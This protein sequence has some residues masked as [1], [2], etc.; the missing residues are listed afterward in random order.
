M[1]NDQAIRTGATASVIAHLSLLALLVLLSEVQPLG[2]AT[3]PIAVNI[4]TTE[5]A[6]PEN[7]KAEHKPDLEPAEPAQV[8]L[9]DPPVPAQQPAPERK[10]AAPSAPQS[11]PPQP[12]AQ[13]QARSER[14]AA[15][16]AAP[17]PVQPSSPPEYQ[18][19]EPDLTV[20]YN[21]MLG[22]PAELPP[23]AAKPGK[24][25]DGFDPTTIAADVKSSVIAELRRHLKSCSKLP[26][27]VQPS[28]HV[29]VKLRIYLT[30]DGRLAADPVV[31]GGSANAKAIELLQGAI[32]GLKRCQPYKMLPADRYGEWKVL[33]L[34]FTPKDF[35][36]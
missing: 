28:D 16:A 23:L 4:V 18:P 33:D 25:E 32:A 27:S 14:R 7:L 15:A 20:K 34:D 9:P 30:Q 11:A 5:E 2:S 21:V 8:A 31:G 17:P 36:G 3:E 22:L 12:P 13:P 10:A 1:E 26:A 24:S 29:M 6:E 35:S 19:P